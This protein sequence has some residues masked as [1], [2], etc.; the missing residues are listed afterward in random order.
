[1]RDRRTVGLSSLDFRHNDQENA[2]AFV[3]CIS[4]FGTRRNIGRKKSP[5]PQDSTYEEYHK[6]QRFAQVLDKETSFISVFFLLIIM[7]FFINNAVLILNIWIKILCNTL[8]K[9]ICSAK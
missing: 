5:R 6:I 4:I 8:C 9:N 3:F 1:M 7:K 2:F